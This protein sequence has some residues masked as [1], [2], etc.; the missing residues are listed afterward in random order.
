MANEKH[1]PFSQ[2]VV[3]YKTSPHANPPHPPTP[4]PRFELLLC[5]QGLENNNL[6][7]PNVHSCLEGKTVC[8]FY[9][10][11][12]IWTVVLEAVVKK[13]VSWHIHACQCIAY[14]WVFITKSEA[15]L[16]IVQFIS[17]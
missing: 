10:V 4:T 8:V 17:S 1:C 6:L 16:E 15:E 5:G 7:V 2:K 3:L 11:S 14:I 13:Y 9:G 12:R